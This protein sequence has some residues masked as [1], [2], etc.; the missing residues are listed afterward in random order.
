MTN[1]AKN[2]HVAKEIA[3]QIGNR[4]LFMI[5]AKQLVA[6]TNKLMFKVGRNA[7]KINHITIELTADDLYK[8][9]FRYIHGMNITVRAEHEGIYCDMLNQM[10]EKETGLYT[11]L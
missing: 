5:G 9:T 11:S 2:Y 8:M 10:I 7:N 4:A 6:D 3:N 1:E